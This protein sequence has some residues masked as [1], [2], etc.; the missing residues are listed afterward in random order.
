M[1]EVVICLCPAI[2]VKEQEESERAVR[3]TNELHPDVISKECKHTE[4]SISPAGVDK[5][6][7]QSLRSKC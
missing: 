2:S 7:V 6:P 5:P 3:R 1:C 4:R